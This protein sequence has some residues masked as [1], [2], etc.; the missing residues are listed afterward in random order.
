MLWQQRERADVVLR[1]R[2]LLES[3]VGWTDVV[4]EW[5]GGGKV[6]VQTPGEIQRSRSL[7]SVEAGRYVIHGVR[8]REEALMMTDA[9][10]LHHCRQGRGCKRAEMSELMLAQTPRTSLSPTSE[11]LPIFF[12]RPD[13]RPSAAASDLVSF[14]GSEDE[15]LD[16]SVSLAAS[17]AEDL[18]W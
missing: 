5:R 3:G 14:G 18:S 2:G 17:D 15:V 4:D 16:D 12:S 13:Q 11:V 8:E 7:P 9:V 10:A 6:K 1:S